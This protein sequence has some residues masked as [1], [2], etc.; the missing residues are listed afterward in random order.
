MIDKLQFRD[1]GDAVSHD[2][3]LKAHAELMQR[4]EWIIDGFGSVATASER[5]A[6]ADTLVYIDL[7]LATHYWWVTK[8][9]AKGLFVAP[10]GW[11]A[12]SPLWSSSLQSYK[13]IGRC[14]RGL[15][16]KYRQYIAEAATSKRIH[17]LQSRADIT[18]FLEAVRREFAV[19]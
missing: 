5:F 2:D 15:T 11:P 12:N 17:H 6:R 3:Y 10:D 4:D 18:A 8:R 1:G 9:L 16:P 19:N 7:P 14:H 13:V